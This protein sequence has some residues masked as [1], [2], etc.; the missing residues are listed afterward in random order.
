MSGERHDPASQFW[1]EMP[2]DEGLLMDLKRG[3]S[4]FELRDCR[5]LPAA[6]TC[7]TQCPKVDQDLT[8]RIH[9]GV[10]K[11]FLY[12]DFFILIY[13]QFFCKILFKSYVKLVQYNI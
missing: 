8:D 12:S 1:K 6:I 3:C 11:T 5:S 7:R 4:S 2:E 9:L 13:L 10:R